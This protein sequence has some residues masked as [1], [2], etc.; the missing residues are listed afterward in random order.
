MGFLNKWELLENDS[1]AFASILV[2]LKENSQG[3][4]TFILEKINSKAIQFSPDIVW[5]MKLL[6]QGKTIDE[7]LDLESGTLIS[8]INKLFVCPLLKHIGLIDKPVA[9]YSMKLKEHEISL[10]TNALQFLEEIG[11]N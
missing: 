2:N 7:K 1:T 8:S 5:K 6:L 3:I 9:Y 10:L 4:G 11:K